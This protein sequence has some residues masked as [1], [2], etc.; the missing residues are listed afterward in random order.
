MTDWRDAPMAYWIHVGLEGQDW[1]GAAHY[2]PAVPMDNGS[3]C[4]PSLHV[5]SKGFVFMFSSR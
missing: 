4:Y 1:R 5:E 2:V 3:G